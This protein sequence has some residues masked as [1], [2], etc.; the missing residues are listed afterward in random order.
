MRLKIVMIYIVFMTY[1]KMIV[2]I[3]ELLVQSKKGMYIESTKNVK[4]ILGLDSEKI[5]FGA[6]LVLL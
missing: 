5:V 6:K 1:L 3:S 2:I 4:K